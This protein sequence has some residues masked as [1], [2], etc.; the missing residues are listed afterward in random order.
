MKKDET[1]VKRLLLY[2]GGSKAN[3]SNLGG[4]TH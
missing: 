4:S 1:D 3:L 2:L